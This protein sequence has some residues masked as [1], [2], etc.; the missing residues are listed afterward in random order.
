[1]DRLLGEKKLPGPC[2]RVVDLLLSQKER[3]RSLS[4]EKD[5]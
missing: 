1:M 3:S 5:P 2:P 4:S